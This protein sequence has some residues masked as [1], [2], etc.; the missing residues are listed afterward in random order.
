MNGP[1]V[2][3]V[4]GILIFG[5]QSALISQGQHGEPRAG[6]F[7]IIGAF[8]CYSLKK[9]RLGLVRNTLLRREC[10]YLGIIL[11]LLMTFVRS[12]LKATMFMYPLECAFIPFLV[13]AIYIRMHIKKHTANTTATHEAII[14]FGSMRCG[15]EV[16]KDVKFC[17]NCQL[18]VV[19]S[20]Q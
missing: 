19:T 14:E 1:I 3:L 20:K 11:I 7:I 13:V 5:S 8:A 4:L 2:S 10:E 17:D 12:N 16:T 6:L 15:R 18:E 9:R